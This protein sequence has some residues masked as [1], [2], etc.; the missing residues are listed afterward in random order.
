MNQSRASPAAVSRVPGSSNRWLAPGT[1]ARWFRQRSSAW[2][3]RDPS[4]LS[5]VRDQAIRDGRG[6]SA[7]FVLGQLTHGWDC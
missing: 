4:A 3:R 6:A 7:A 5:S 2:A 1:T